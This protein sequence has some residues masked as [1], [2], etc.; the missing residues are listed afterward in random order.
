MLELFNI[1][2]DSI[3]AIGLAIFNIMLFDIGLKSL[4]S[5]FEYRP[6]LGFNKAQCPDYQILHTQHF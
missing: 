5:D 1:R 6:Y 3:V 2:L 4:L